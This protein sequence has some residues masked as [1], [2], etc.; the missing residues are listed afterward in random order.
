MNFILNMILIGFRTFLRR[1]N[2]VIFFGGGGAKILKMINTRNYK[3]GIALF[4]IA[5]TQFCLHAEPIYIYKD[6]GS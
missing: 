3:K 2:T 4:V 6:I 1:N 5:K